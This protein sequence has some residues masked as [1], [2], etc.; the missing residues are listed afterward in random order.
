MCFSL[1]ANNSKISSNFEIQFLLNKVM[2]NVYT[3]MRHL[4][5]MS[6]P[7]AI[8]VVAGALQFDIS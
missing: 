3:K 6:L 5:H 7:L 1:I 4:Y 2:R 8:I